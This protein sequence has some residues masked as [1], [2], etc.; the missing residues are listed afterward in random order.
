MKATTI[1]LQIV[2]N[3]GNYETV[4]LGGEWSTDGNSTLDAFKNA[5]KELD[6]AFEEL[7]K[8]RPAEVLND[9]D[10]LTPEHPR[11]ESVISGLKSGK[12]SM[13][14]INDMYKITPEAMEI[15]I[16]HIF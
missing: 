1:T 6:A 5:K 3:L 4:R 11:F 7:F 10:I 9:K 8:D 12:V 2:R 16:N 15:I 13:I 14:V